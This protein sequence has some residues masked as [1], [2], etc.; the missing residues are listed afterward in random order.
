MKNL[1]FIKALLKKVLIDQDTDSTISFE[2][3]V[4]NIPKNLIPEDF[5]EEG[6]KQLRL[7]DEERILYNKAYNSLRKENQCEY[8]KDSEIRECLNYLICKVYFNKKKYNNLNKFNNL[9]N[10]F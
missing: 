10:A 1:K 4:I 2:D 3:I 8:L 5:L 7:S 6:I 9:V